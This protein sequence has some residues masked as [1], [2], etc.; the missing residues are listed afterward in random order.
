[1]PRPLRIEF[2]DACYHVICRGNTRLPIFQDKYSSQRRELLR[3]HNRN[4]EAPQVLLYFAA[5]GCRE[6]YSLA[7]PGQRLGPISL[8][9]VGNAR[10]GMQ[11]RMA[12]DTDLR[13]RISTMRSRLGKGKLDD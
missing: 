2:P 6:R 7:E 13:N 5:V 11:Q 1:M 3:R 8:A 10:T 4:C 9:A 12:E